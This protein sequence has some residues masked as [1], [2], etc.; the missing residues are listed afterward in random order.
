MSY[1]ASLR[2]DFETEAIIASHFEWTMNESSTIILTGLAIE[3]MAL[4]SEHRHTLE[5]IRA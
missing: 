5:G 1:M 4:V 2:R 3:K